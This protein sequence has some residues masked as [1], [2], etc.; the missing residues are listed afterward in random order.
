MGVL[1]IIRSPLPHLEPTSLI[2]EHQ[3]LRWLARVGVG[4]DGDVGHLV[5]EEVF[6][7]LE[8]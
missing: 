1:S 2:T 7:G 3:A 6:D 5:L 4:Q 8:D